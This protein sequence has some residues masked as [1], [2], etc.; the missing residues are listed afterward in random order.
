MIYKYSLSRRQSLFK[1]SFDIFLSFLLLCFLL[2]PILLLLVLSSIY[3]RSSGLFVQRGWKAWADFQNSK[4]RSMYHRVSGSTITSVN[5]PRI[6]PFGLFLRRYKLDELPQLFNIL[7]GDMSFVGPRPDVPGYADCLTGSYRS[8]LSLRPGIT[9]PASIVFRNEEILLSK[10][11]DPKSFND[12]YIWPR[13]IKLNLCYLQSW[14]F[15]KDLCLF[16]VQFLTS[17]R[18]CLC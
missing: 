3:H 18:F 13:K 6:S 11:S 7:L 10:V 8:I 12:N 2:L 16:F 1:R 15:R 14:S 17:S 9:G 5:D 4:I